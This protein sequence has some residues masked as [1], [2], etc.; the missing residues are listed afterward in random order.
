MVMGARPARGTGHA[1]ARSLARAG[2]VVTLLVSWGIAHA[3]GDDG[4]QRRPRPLAFEANRGQAE[5]PVKYLAR[6]AGFNV[7]LTP[8][9]A[10]VAL[11][12]GRSRPAVLR[13]RPMGASAEAR[14]SAEAD[15]PG[16]V[17][18]ATVARGGQPVTV[19]TYARVRY[20]DLYP[21]V[22]LV[23]YGR[24]RHLEY[25]F[26]VRPH[27]DPG[28]IALTFDGAERVEVDASGDLVLHT[29]AGEL[30]QPRPVVY[31]EIDG[32]RRAVTGG[33]AIDREGRVRI[34]LGAYDASRTLIIDPVLAYSTYL[35]G[36]KEEADWLWGG[37]V[38]LAVDAAGNAY[39]TGSTTSVDFPTTPGAIRTLSGDQDVFVTK[40]SPTGAGLSSSY[41]GGPCS[42]IA[43]A[44]AVDAAGNA[45]ITGR[46]HGGVC[47]ADVTSGALVAKLSPTGT[48]LY[49]FVFGGSMA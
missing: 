14:L 45:Y 13:V 17:N 48:L 40:L 24:P 7:F 25:D 20:A 23:Y 41:L 49:S 10:V 46:A 33:Y 47:W 9:E 34:Q 43:R 27:A 30:R 1:I 32:D 18:Y 36:S 15:L 22:D 4:H 44:I 39:V 3:G 11:S 35:G 12:D 42:A 21:G 8:T 19:P 16:V 5:E 2:I 28:Q 37:G 6:G 31:Q 26:A 29:A 38:G